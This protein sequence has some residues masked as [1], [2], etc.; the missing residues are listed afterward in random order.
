MTS[1]HPSN[2][3]IVKIPTHTM[4]K[5]AQQTLLASLLLVASIS[6]ATHYAGAEIF[7]EHVAG[8]T[9]DYCITLILYGDSSSNVHLP[10]ATTIFYR[11]SCHAGGQVLVNNTSGVTGFNYS[12]DSLM[13]DQAYPC[14]PYDPNDPN[15]VPY[16]RL[17]YTTCITLPVDCD[18]WVFEWSDFARNNAISNLQNPGAQAL[19]IRASLNNNYGQ[20]SSPIFKAPPVKQFCVKA[21]SDPPFNLSQFA[22]EPD[23]DSLE[24]TLSIPLGTGCNPIPFTA[25]YSLNA[26]MTTWNGIN[27][28]AA[29]GVFTFSPS[30]AE[31]VVIKVDVNEYRFD[32]LITQS[33]VFIGSTS[34]D[35]QVPIVSQC[36]SSILAGP[37]IDLSQPGFSMGSISADS[38]LSVYG[39]DI[40]PG[41]T[42]FVNSNGQV[43][44][45]VPIVDYNCFDAEV[46][47]NFN[48]EIEVTSISP[49]GN[50]FRIIGPDGVT[51]PVIGVEWAV[52]SSPIH[53]KEIRLK[54]HKKLD[55]NGLYVMYIKK[56]SD[57][58]T[59]LNECGFELAPNFAMLIKVENCPILDYNLT[60]LTVVE[61]RNRKIK[62]SITDPSYLQ[63]DL[64]N[65]WRVGMKVG[66]NSYSIEVDDINAR[67]Y[68]DVSE[69]FDNQV[70]Y[71]NYEYSIQ[72]VQNADFKTPGASELTTVKLRSETKYLGNRQ[73]KLVL[74]WNAYNLLDTASTAYQLYLGSF[75]EQ[76]STLLSWEPYG[77]NNPNYFFNDY[78]IDESI[79]I[80]DGLFAFRVDATDINNPPS[81]GGDISESNWL[82]FKVNHEDVPDLSLVQPFAPNVFS[83]NSDHKNDNFYI[84]GVNG[85]R[86][87]AKVSLTV[88]NRWGQM[89]YENN[90]F[91]KR[92]NAQQGWDGTDIYTGQKLADGV[93][94]YVAKLYDPSTDHE[95][96]L[97]GSVTILGS[98]GSN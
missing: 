81:T 37:K 73:Q 59:L 62:W 96:D 45:N 97:Q 91:A 38:L 7:Y 21:Q 44:Y 98:S 36:N 78:L 27:V 13:V 43:S 16:Y 94:Y 51:R 28:N 71:Q 61:D 18:D 31:V 69:F 4:K 77:N 10:A 11:S 2:F 53:S 68:L 20:N 39:F 55:E 70:D 32:S 80:N 35:L 9:R 23:G 63:P 14:A 92:N 42:D 65:Y 86:E 83:P 19:C 8:T 60:N 1:H 15:S 34:R 46:T 47:L 56:G 5:L 12:R 66:R 85:A 49:E 40:I 50:E 3:I 74:G 90:Q 30:Q 95:E 64:F 41:N 24:Y 67:E 93:Y 87:F 57:G 29:S 22:I 26:P 79:A 25:G 89:V 84:S 88:Y 17:K 54:L 75:N 6:S 58:N 33:W 82:F 52:G 76:D 72:L 48:P